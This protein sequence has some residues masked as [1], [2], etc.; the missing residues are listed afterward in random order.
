MDEYERAERLIVDRLGAVRI[1]S[2]VAAD[3]ARAELEAASATKPKRQPRKTWARGLRDAERAQIDKPPP[4]SAK[5]PREIRP[6]RD[7]EPNDWPRALIMSS[8]TYD[9]DAAYWHSPDNPAHE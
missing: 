4:R 7:R 6:A 5:V 3:M 9:P 2:G 1:L 8:S